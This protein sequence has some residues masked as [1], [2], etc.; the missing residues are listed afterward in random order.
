MIAEAA[1]TGHLVLTALPAS[2]A[3]SALLRLIDMGLEPYLVSATVKGVVAMRLCRRVCENCKQPVNLS[4]EPALS[5][6]RPAR[7]RGRL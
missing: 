5:Y 2:D 7:R 4:A 3:P 1:L 6:R